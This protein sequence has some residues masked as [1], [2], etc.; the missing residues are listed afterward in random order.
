MDYNPNTGFFSNA[1]G[2][3]Q[4]E[5]TGYTSRTPREAPAVDNDYPHNP[6]IDDSSYDAYTVTSE[7]RIV[8][9]G[10]MG[11][12]DVFIG[13]GENEIPAYTGP[14]GGPIFIDID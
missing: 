6:F 10:Y 2:S 9:C 1:D 3:V 13:K 14:G 7:I 12:S 11:I 8:V 4:L 5:P